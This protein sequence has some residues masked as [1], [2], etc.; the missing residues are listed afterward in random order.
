MRKRRQIST[1][2]TPLLDVIMIILFIIISGNNEAVEKAETEKEEIYSQM[3][4][5]SDEF[6]KTLEENNDRLNQAENIISGYEM[7]DKLAVII[8]LSIENQSDDSRKILISSDNETST[9]SY[10]WDNMRYGENS[11][12]ASLENYIKS[13]D[14]RP[15]FITFSYKSSEIYLRDYNMISSVM[16]NIQSKSEN[17]YIMYNE[18]EE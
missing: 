14:E 15:V 11:L 6:E 10:S 4:S 18:M 8:S 1:E 2:L 17:I 7:F 12:N 3:Q 13:A 5:V 16:D 9:V